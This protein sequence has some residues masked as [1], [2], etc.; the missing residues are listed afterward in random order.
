VPVKVI[1]RQRVADLP[2]DKAAG[3]IQVYQAAS[4]YDQH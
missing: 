2:A 4:E 3:A 1:G